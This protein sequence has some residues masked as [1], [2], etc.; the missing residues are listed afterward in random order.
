MSDRTNAFLDCQPG[1]QPVPAVPHPAP[2][3]GRAGTTDQVEPHDIWHGMW[4]GSLPALEAV[5][6]RH[7]GRTLYDA[8]DVFLRSRMFGVDARLA[9][10]HPDPLRASLGS[11]RGRG[12]PGQRAVRRR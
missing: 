3:I 4:A 2:S 7:G 11:R 5:R 6:K 8:R 1:D 10:A 12:H 9:A